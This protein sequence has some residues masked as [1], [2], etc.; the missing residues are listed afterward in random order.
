MFA[1]RSTSTADF[2]LDL[3]ELT[4]VGPTS[5]EQAGSGQRTRHGLA[6]LEAEGLVASAAEAG[7]IR[8]RTTETG[9]AALER[10]GRIPGRGTV[11]FTDIVGSTEL[12]A[13]LGEEGAHERRKRHFSLLRDAIGGHR[14]RE[15]KRLGDGVMAVFSDPAAATACAAEMQRAVAAD[16]DRLGLR[17]GVH[18]GDLLHDGDDLYGTTVIVAARLCD[19]ARA[20]ET[21]VSDATHALSDGA[22]QPVRPLGD[23]ALAGLPD[24]VTAYA[25]VA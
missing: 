23:L 16:P 18:T 21:I 14:G 6:T 8:Y 13:A 25:A 7:V 17:I 2:L 5:L 10:R 20:G 19:R 15:V 11:L 9:L 4:S 12:I 3:L 24:P 22:D 1:T